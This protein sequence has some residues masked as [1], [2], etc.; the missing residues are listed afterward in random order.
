MTANPTTAPKTPRR[1]LSLRSI[2]RGLA[3]AIVACWLLAALTLVAFKWIDPPTTAVHMERRVE[4]WI[5]HKPYRLRYQF[6]PLSQIS[7]DMQHAVIAAEDGRFYEHHGF[8]WHAIELAAEQDEKGGHRL[9]GGSTIT[10]QLVK[11]LLLGTS[12]SY[13]RKAAEF[14]LVPVAELVLG[15]QR[16]LELYLNEVEWG[17]GIYGVEAASRAYYG[18]SARKID[19]D[20]AARLAAILPLPLKRRPDRMDHYSS[21]IL[22]HMREMGW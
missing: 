5:H 3:I 14:T 1:K 19:R 18:K 16:I 6:V 8:D 10:Q 13:L 22:D 20:E 15:K 21:I 11:N 12:R 7:P 17:P 9:R 4:A 2:L